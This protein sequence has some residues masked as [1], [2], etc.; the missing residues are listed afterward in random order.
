MKKF[1]LK[2]FNLQNTPELLQRIGNMGLIAAGIG[3]LIM[4]T[5][6]TLQAAGLTEIVLPAFVMTIGKVCI[7]IGVFTKMF[8]K[9][10]GTD[11]VK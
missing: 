7:A 4:G 5:P 6:A 2:N 3:T 11:E 8:T 9:L 1:S 10:F